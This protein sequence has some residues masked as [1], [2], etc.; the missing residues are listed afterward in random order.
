VTE[1]IKNACEEKSYIYSP[2]FA[3][4]QYN[5]A[6]GKYLPADSLGCESCLRGYTCAG[7]IYDYNATNDQGIVINTYT[8]SSGYFLPANSL[9]CVACPTDATCSGGTFT[10]NPT[11]AQGININYPVTHNLTNSCEEKSYTYSPTFTINS[12]TCASG[13]YLPSDSLGC[14]SCLRGHTCTAGT[15]TYNATNDQGIAIN[16]YTCASGEYL[17]ADGLACESCL[18]GHTCAGGT[19]NYD[20]DDDQGIAV[21]SYTCSSGQYLPANAIAC[22]TCPTGHTCSGGTFNFNAKNFQGLVLDTD[23]PIPANTN[24]CAENFPESLKATYDINTYTCSPGYYLPANATECVKCLE[25]NYCVGGSYTFNPTTDQGIT[26]CSGDLRAPAGMW[27]A[28]Q[29]GRRLNIGGKYVYSR[30]TRKTH[31]SI[32]LDMDLDG[33]TEFYISLST[34][35]VPM[36]ADFKNLTEHNKLVIDLPKAYINSAGIY[37]PAGKYY[38]YDDT[39]TN[40]TPFETAE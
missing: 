11:T 19:F 9:G 33:T 40:A 29:C 21:N 18:R 2:T 17:P 34:T 3:I 7:G 13:E 26:H 12:Y 36:N 35:P 20:E 28:E 5:C 30:S 27:E 14:E 16:S 10:F 8:C 38:A 39:I 32:N 6:S 25:N 1:D 15:Y 23:S 31:P 22:E 4:N 37:I 24:V